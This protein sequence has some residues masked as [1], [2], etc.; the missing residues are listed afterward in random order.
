MSTIS[1]TWRSPEAQQLMQHMTTENMQQGIYDKYRDS[2]QTTLQEFHQSNF[3]ELLSRA[4]VEVVMDELQQA[5]RTELP[6]LPVYEQGTIAATLNLY[7]VEPATGEALS[8][9]GVRV[10][11]ASSQ[12]EGELTAAPP[13]EP[14]HME[15]LLDQVVEM[16]DRDLRVDVSQTV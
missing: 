3:S 8:G 4:G 10:A 12:S 7:R 1:N 2:L 11:T 13:F 15:M 16:H 6:I 14:R 9:S 5:L